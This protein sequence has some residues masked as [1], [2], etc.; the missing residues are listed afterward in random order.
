MDKIKKLLTFKIGII[1]LPIA[2]L[3]VS[4]LVIIASIAGVSIGYEETIRQ[5]TENRGSNGIVNN[6]IYASRY[7]EILN[8]YLIDKGYVSLERLIFYLQRKNNILDITTLSKD[9]WKKAYIDNLNEDNMRM[10][11][12]KTICKSLKSDET[13]K[14][15]TISNGMN[16]DGIYIEVIDLCTVDGIDITTSNEYSESYQYLPYVF[17]LV[18]DFSTTSMVFEIRD[19]DL[20]LSGEAQDRANYHNGWDFAVPIGTN[21]YSVCDGIVSNVVNTQF[22]DF[23]YTIS[24]N[25]TGNYITVK[26]NNEMTISYH[27]IQA[28]S[29]PFNIKNGSLVK[30]G[31]LL[32][33]TSTTGLSTGPHLHL[34]LTNQ[35]GQYLDAL[36]YIDFSYKKG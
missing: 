4:I 32:G 17:P 21:F 14:E 33:R 31:D 11:P 6:Q 15:F 20:G 26:C 34:G 30:K 10:I 1:V 16:E 28:N 3:F 18:S 13:I 2:I 19:V 24:G 29:S 5:A 23:K 35:E 36:E 7:K 9:E 25:S 12:I 8:K 27:H 22:N